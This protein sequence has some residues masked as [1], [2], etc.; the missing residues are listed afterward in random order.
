VK[1][2]SFR[3]QNFH[4][5]DD[6]PDDA[7]AS[8]MA[9]VGTTEAGIGESLS[10]VPRDL[11]TGY[12]VGLVGVAAPFSPEVSRAKGGLSGQ[13]AFPAD[14][15]TTSIPPSESLRLEDYQRNAANQLTPESLDIQKLRS[16]S[17]ESDQSDNLNNFIRRNR[18]AQIAA[19]EAGKAQAKAESDPALDI[20]G[21][22][23][24]ISKE[25]QAITDASGFSRPIISG[26]AQSVAGMLPIAVAGAG[27]IVGGPVAAGAYAGALGIGALQQ[28]TGAYDEAYGRYLKQG[29]SP[30]VADDRAKTD[31][32][33]SGGIT[34][35]VTAGFGPVANKVAGPIISKLTGGSKMVGG[36]IEKIFSHQTIR[37]A[38]LEEAVEE[39][40][41]QGL[42]MILERMRSNPDLTLGDAVNQV[43][44]AGVGGAVG[45]GIFKGGAKALESAARRVAGQPKTVDQVQTNPNTKASSAAVNGMVR[46]A[47]GSSPLAAG[48]VAGMNATLNDADVD[49]AAARLASDG[50]AEEKANISADTTEGAAPGAVMPDAPDTINSQIELAV[51]PD[52]T[53]AA[54]LLTPRQD[55]WTPDLESGPGSLLDT[56][57]T[58][59][60]WV[61]FNPSKVT[62]EQVIAAGAGE[63]F[64]ARLLGM[65]TADRPAGGQ[66]PDG[67]NVT[68]SAPDGTP[69]VLSQQVGSEAEIPAAIAAGQASSPGGESVVTTNE[70]LL[71]GRVLADEAANLA[72]ARGDGPKSGTD[73]AVTPTTTS[74]DS[75]AAHGLAETS[76]ANKARVS[77]DSHTQAIQQAVDRSDVGSHNVDIES[78][79]A[80]YDVAYD[81]ATKRFKVNPNRVTSPASVTLKLNTHE[82]LHFVVDALRE[83]GR[84]TEADQLIDAMAAVAPDELIRAI[85]KYYAGSTDGALTEEQA[86]YAAQ[87]FGKHFARQGWFHRLTAMVSKILSQV[88]GDKSKAAKVAAQMAAGRIQ[89]LSEEFLKQRRDGTLP[90]GELRMSRPEVDAAT[91]R[92]GQT[93]SEVRHERVV[94]AN[95]RQKLAGKYLSLDS[96]LNPENTAKFWEI[97]GGLSHPETGMA[98]ANQINADAGGV[99]AAANLMQA[100]LKNYAF[101]MRGAGDPSLDVF[102]QNAALVMRPGTPDNNTS[103]GQMQRA[104]QETGVA[105]STTS[106]ASQQIRSAI[107]WVD[108]HKSPD[109]TASIGSDLL[110]RLSKRLM[111]PLTFDQMSVDPGKGSK[112]FKAIKAL[113]DLQRRTRETTGPGGPDTGPGG[114][115]RRKSKAPPTPREIL[116]DLEEPD[117]TIKRW[118]DRIE[119]EQTEWL[120]PE[121]KVSQVTK[122]LRE[123]LSDRTNMTDTGVLFREELH[124]KLV[125]IGAKPELANQVAWDIHVKRL[126]RWSAQR[127]ASQEAARIALDART[128]KA[129]EA[130]AEK[131]ALEAARENQRLIE[132]PTVDARKAIDKLTVDRPG[133]TIRTTEL[134]QAIKEASRIGEGTAPV[135]MDMDHVAPFVEGWRN[136]FESHGVDA[137][138]AKELAFTIAMDRMKRQAKINA[139]ALAKAGEGR[140]DDGNFKSSDTGWLMKMIMATPVLAQNN[141]QWRMDT[142][143]RFYMGK[144][145]SLDQA[146]AATRLFE[147]VF[148]SQMAAAQYE[149]AKA[150]V[151][152]SVDVDGKVKLNS[153]EKIRN[154]IRSQIANPDAPFAEALATEYGWKSPF[155]KAQY[156]E[157][158]RIDAMIQGATRH[159]QAILVR[160]TAAI[161]RESTMA[162]TV[163]EKVT[164]AYV[165]NALSGI[166]TLVVNATSTLMDSAALVATETARSFGD[167]NP[168]AR[169]A[170]TFGGLIDAMSST[171]RELMFSARHDA[172]VNL[173]HQEVTRFNSL[174]DLTSNALRD[175]R[176]PLVS[177]PAK[178]TATVNGL[179][180]LIDV[181]RRV[182]S[183]LDNSFSA[184]IR[185]FTE[186]VGVRDGYKGTGLDSTRAF[187]LASAARAVAP[188]YIREGQ[189]IGLTGSR[190]S[191]YVDDRIRDTMLSGGRGA[192][193]DVDSVQ[194][195]AK[196]IL[197]L[198]TGNFAGKAKTD[199]A[200]DR[201]T[202]IGSMAE[203]IVGSLENMLAQ[204]PLV[205]RIVIGFL[206]VPFNRIAYSFNYSGAG[207]LRLAYRYAVLRSG[208]VDPYEKSMRTA[209]QRQLIAT[210]GLMGLAAMGTIGYLLKESLTGQHD[211]KEEWV[212]DATAGQIASENDRKLM[213]ANGI[214]PSRPN[215]FMRNKRTGE[216]RRL[217]ANRGLLEPFG[218]WITWAGGIRDMQRRGKLLKPEEFQTI[219]GMGTLAGSAIRGTAGMTHNFGVGNIADF[220]DSVSSSKRAAATAG[221]ML[222][223]FM[224][225]GSL[226]NSVRRIAEDKP[227]RE[228][229]STAFWSSF[230][231]APPNGRQPALNWLGHPVQGEYDGA[232]ARIV[233]KATESA[234]PIGVRLPAS[235]KAWPLYRLMLE[236]NATPTAIHIQDLESRLGTTVTPDQWR[237]YVQTRGSLIEGMMLKSIGGLSK[238]PSEVFDKAIDKMSKDAGKQA[239]YRIFK[240]IPGAAPKPEK[241]KRELI[242]H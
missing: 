164:A 170:Q 79:D 120:K 126:A 157:L 200:F 193:I 185:E 228:T 219:E 73:T 101:R 230:A 84:D 226:V 227:S 130:A 92:F 113:L 221:F 155:T 98:Y 30:E 195:E 25:S 173:E 112:V 146:Q 196:D 18:D 33:V 139:K 46:N 59:H 122:I 8:E 236:K 51:K 166:P 66:S 67:L 176:N 11:V 151:E 169:L 103:I 106:V 100:T 156:N 56:V 108:S 34:A 205:G 118:I 77:S 29:L 45:A 213:Q 186:T 109:G 105:L 125:A 6:T 199:A 163:R 141:P 36:S 187:A 202:P 222:S 238:L 145:L 40:T 88:T 234:F 189:A 129:K 179:V 148:R 35:A 115:R 75:Q 232:A 65:S 61:L 171:A 41:D 70:E 23:K 9:R 180:G 80:P 19:I 201:G 182:L 154:A 93:E 217:Q 1:I 174:A 183:T 134:A 137:G 175:L 123:A 60:G 44:Q 2:V 162:P 160:R 4:F 211:D 204:F 216:V 159:E 188:Q 190:L 52:S 212:I 47:V 240:Y 90:K 138:V 49:Q 78:S 233:D 242:A 57:E 237:Q 210:Q 223:G 104:L 63:N 26:T 178:L 76:S 215:M 28:G 128:E 22:Q 12:Q 3:G 54:V 152:Q 198:A 96:P 131:D 114:P 85:Q 142:A 39:M 241:P 95:V 149:A 203:A 214:D 231:Y 89:R 197:E 124:A 191:M 184:G 32:I 117:S 209:F 168:T 111:A 224:P 208:G 5:P 74:F 110:T 239:E 218:W 121:T 181:F 71:R 127:A 87:Q 86:A 43:V 62:E 16:R 206:R 83:A 135:A 48:M 42:Q 37:A 55:G 20:F 158:A 107:G 220:T 229:V 68:T 38:V 72:A 81:P 69:D 192:G 140:G 14:E 15:R 27:G 194:Q 207:L 144:G 143:T 150:V 97:A 31:A 136:I 7:I 53:R 116:P 119:K 161:M 165:L 133:R 58:P 153:L 50:I 64:D 94:F 21:A 102:M 17:V 235:D 167:S 24:E 172:Y 177:G 10:R 225:A 132:Q 82:K 99:P 91:Q 13:S 147:F